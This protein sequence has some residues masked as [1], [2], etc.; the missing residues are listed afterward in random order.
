MAH[1]GFGLDRERLSKAL[2]KLVGR[3]WI[4]EGGDDPFIGAPV[5]YRLVRPLPAR[6]VEQTEK[7]TGASAR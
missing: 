4:T 3:S 7:P 6:G 2:R 5:A 1:S